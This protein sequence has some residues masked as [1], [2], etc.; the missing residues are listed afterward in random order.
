MRL[1]ES[2][3]SRL[4]AVCLILLLLF[5]GLGLTF[6]RGLERLDLMIYD[7]MLP[8]HA[9]SM[10]DQVVIVAI[11]DYS[12][13]QLGRWPWSRKRHAEL[14]Y[15]LTEMD[16]A[17]IGIDVLFVEPQKDDP[18]ADDVFS[19]A[20]LRSGRS[21]LSIA[22][23][24]QMPG[25]LISEVMPLPDLAI[26]AEAIGH[27][28]V[29]LDVDGLCRRFFLYSGVGDARWPA[30]AM[31]MLRVNGE[32]DQL[33]TL[34][35]V[36]NTP[37]I[38]SDYWLRRQSIM[39]PFAKTGERPQTYSWADIIAD[40]VP[41]EAIQGKYVLVGAT[42]TGLGD[43]LSTPAAAAHERIPGVELN[44]HI[45]NALLWGEGIS[46]VT[47]AWYVGV[48]LAFICLVTLAVVLLPLRAGL[49]FTLTILLGLPIL[50][51]TLLVGWQLWF[52]PTAALIIVALPWPLWNVWQ[53]GI[54]ARLKHKL[55]QQLAHQVQH[56]VATGL[57]NSVMLRQRLSQAIA[58]QEGAQTCVGLLVIH[59]NWSGSASTALECP[60]DD[61]QLQFVGK[62]L[63]EIISEEYFIAHL[64]G[65][66]FAVLLTDLKEIEH[67]KDAAVSL[68]SS[69]QQPLKM[70]DESY[71]LLT[72]RIGASVWP[73]DCFDAA[74]LI[75]N[76]YTAMF[77]SRV[78]DSDSLC[79]YSQ[80]AG[81]QLELRSQV[82]QALVHA[83]D[84]GEFEIYYQPQVRADTGRMVGVEALLRWNSPQL[85]RIP[86]GIFI[87]VA[88]HVGLIPMIGSWV[89]KTAC[90]QL[91]DWHDAGLP[92]IR[93]AINVS[94]LQFADPELER[95]LAQTVQQ[96]NVSPGD[97]E[98]EITEGSLMWDMDQAVT[99]M[100]RMKAQ[101]VDLA[102]DDFGTG[103]SSLS[104]LRHFPLDRLKIDQS[105]TRE[106]GNDDA[107][108]E[109]TLT[110]ISMGKRLGL[111]IIAEGVETAEQAD[112][113]RKHGCDEFQGHYF[114]RPLDA[115]Q[116]TDLLVDIMIENSVKK[117]SAAAQ[118]TE[119]SI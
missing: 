103:Y 81:L 110:I 82:E 30:L 14:V 2:H 88:E 59:F 20:L 98:L 40:R 43:A 27:V 9:V 24:V 47:P 74:G 76:A 79:I 65:D 111:R 113:L 44:A 63:R 83:L 34:I 64:N 118:D 70:D 115:D 95:R 22:P 39:I 10:S 5:S 19:E 69:L 85:G 93:L 60:V 6:N 73:E 33:E 26:S 86:P 116:I 16:A 21:V 99:I 52:A 36:E 37:V 29:E 75:R 23:G 58:E 54:D 41:A 117:S 49:I 94:P 72:P 119:E 61:K 51:L 67:V 48:T 1:S 53:L 55:L 90:E 46:E 106:I 32:T 12:L 38:R 71:L 18:E 62:R 97:L 114:G 8:A 66:D 11:D 96:L 4:Y 7:Q 100:K 78:D 45:L 15:K 56:H 105:F 112:F 77:K 92:R 31:A 102:V 50:S 91:Q 17:V 107:A 108:T 42:A 89:L 109:I 35:N 57:P 25:S 87:P 3:R 84:R 68:L 104:S 80:G 28:D 13:Q 101:G